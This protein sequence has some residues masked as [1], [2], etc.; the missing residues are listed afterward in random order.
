MTTWEYGNNNI[1]EISGKLDGFQVGGEALEG[2]GT[3][4]ENMIFS[5]YIREIKNAPIDLIIHDSGDGFLAY[6]ESTTLT[7]KVTHGWNDITDNVTSWSIVR[8]SG[9]QADDNV[10]NIN[11]T[12]FNG[13]ITLTHT[14]AYS[15][16]GEGISTLFTITA[17]GSTESG[18][19]FTRETVI[20]I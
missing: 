16:L 20:T 13:I 5:G 10:W 2:H 19:G 1:Y 8:E 6:G 3:S 4:V 12:D 17:K 9:N 15:D 14:K 7:G 11:H 18:Q